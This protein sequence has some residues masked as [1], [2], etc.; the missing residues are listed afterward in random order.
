M[1]S[2][3]I[4]LDFPRANGTL[5][6]IGSVVTTK[7]NADTTT[8][9]HN[10]TSTVALASVLA[11]HSLVFT[12]VDGGRVITLTASSTPANE[13]EFEIDG[14]TNADDATSLAAAIN[15]H[16]YLPGLVT[17]TVSSATITL[18]AKPG[19]PLLN[20]T[21][22]TGATLT[23]TR[24]GRFGQTLADR[25]LVI[26]AA[27]D[28]RIGFGRSSAEAIAQADSTNGF[29]LAEGASR[30]VHVR[31]DFTHVASTGGTIR[32]YEAL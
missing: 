32:V 23:I 13:N 4:S 1:A 14:A 18:T 29:L 21:Q 25:V 6:Y 22:G 2:N 15:A 10:A 8:P 5:F 28:T 9:F 30:V 27:A 7:S 26:Q 20:L 11:T 12:P 24:G 16:S 19:C 3:S 31:G 17:A